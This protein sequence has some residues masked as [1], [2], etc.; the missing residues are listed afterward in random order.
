MTE[1]FVASEE[2]LEFIERISRET[3]PDT[4]KKFMPIKLIE[5]ILNSNYNKSVIAQQMR[6]GHRFILVS[7][8]KKKIGYFS[9]QLDYKGLPRMMIHKIYILPSFQ[10]FGIGKQIFNYLRRV[11]LE[12]GQTSFT[13]K[14]FHKNDKAISFY[15]NEGFNIVGNK[16]VLYDEKFDGFA[17]LDYVMIK[18]L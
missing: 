4:F 8:N 3:W 18:D 7:Y 1:F 15:R 17:V 14:V 16:K 13:L 2:D 9:F 11:A 6:N 5:H 10:G 12:F